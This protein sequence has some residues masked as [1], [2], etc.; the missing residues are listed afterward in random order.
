MGSS[1]TILVLYQNYTL[2]EYCTYVKVIMDCF[3]LQST[4]L[5]FQSL[6]GLW[7]SM[8]LIEEIYYMDPVSMFTQRGM[9]KSEKMVSAIFPYYQFLDQY[10]LPT[11]PVT[12]LNILIIKIQLSKGIHGKKKIQP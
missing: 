12:I 3:P 5:I 8:I 7:A 1:F 2:V 4:S 6:A 11:R 10:F 9:Y